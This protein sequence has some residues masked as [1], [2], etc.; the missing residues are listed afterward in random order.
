LSPDH[1]TRIELDYICISSRWRSSFQGCGADCGSDHFLLT[2]KMKLIFK[3]LS[4]SC[5]QKSLDLGKL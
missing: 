3:R 4:K 5:T 2:G 1:N